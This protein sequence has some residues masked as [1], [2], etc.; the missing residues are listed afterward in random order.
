M[1]SKN[2]NATPKPRAGKLIFLI[3]VMLAVVIAVVYFLK[4]E[5]GSGAAAGLE[6]VSGEVALREITGS[7][8]VA[9][10]VEEAKPKAAFARLPGRWLRED[11]GYVIEISQVE[12]DGKLKA[13]YFNPHPIHVSQ[14][15]AVEEGGSVKVGLELNDVNYP[16]C[17]YTLI[18]NAELDQLQ[19]TYFQA[20]IGQTYQVVFIRMPVE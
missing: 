5:D 14:A 13:A 1:S 8:P 7:E 20:A 19:G 3:F 15:A 6:T 17:L 18:F 9:T 10:E 16:G 12:P 2:K 4:R 11:G